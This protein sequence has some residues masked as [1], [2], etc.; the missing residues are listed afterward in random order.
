MTQ[1]DESIKKTDADIR[2]GVLDKLAADPDINELDL[3]VD[4]TE[5]GV[6]LMGSVDAYW[7][8]DYA[9]KIITAERGVAFIENRLAV[10]PAEDLL[11]QAIAKDIVSSLEA[12]GAAAP[13]KIDVLVVDGNVTLAGEASNGIARRAAEEAARYA[14]GVKTV[15]NKISVGGA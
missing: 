9:E 14:A 2:D 7:K 5:G 13:E 12:S 4:V 6:T 11:D 1:K 15:E 3:E 10:A 8:K